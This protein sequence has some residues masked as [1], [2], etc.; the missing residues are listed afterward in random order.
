MKQILKYTGILLALALVVGAFSAFSSSNE[1][2]NAM[3]SSEVYS[4][5][6]DTLN[7]ADNVTFTVP[8]VFT[9]PYDLLVQGWMDEISGTA[10]TIFQ[11]QISCADSGTDF[12][13]TVKSDT[14][15]ADG[16]FLVNNATT[17]TVVIPRNIRRCRV[18]IAQT[19]T[20]VSSVD[21]QVSAKRFP[22]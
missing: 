14:L 6:V 2:A 21:L 9:N 4:F 12:W 13:T 11:T 1:D 15:T 7:N 22:N 16:T 10:T 3:R 8:D 19:G 20:A 5:T 18:V 17:S